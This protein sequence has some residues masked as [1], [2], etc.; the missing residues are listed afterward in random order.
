M[1]HFAE[2]NLAELTPQDIRAAVAVAIAVGTLYCFLGYR[3]LKFVLGITGFILAGAVAGI[4]AGLATGGKLLYMGA[5]AILGGVAGAM[6][7]YFLYKVGVLCLGVIAAALLAQNFLASRPEPWAPS[8]VVG[9]AVFGGLAALLF[10]RPIMTAATAAIG[11]WIC[12]HGIAF[13]V[14]G[15][16]S[17]ETMQTAVEETHARNWL[18]LCWIVLAVAGAITQFAT[19]KPKDKTGR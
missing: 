13:F 16:G 18:L 8:A 2:L 1:R 9:A 6:A 3:V 17:S 15:Y 19:H 11:A 12:V 7:L 4:L 10:E 5:A 14:I